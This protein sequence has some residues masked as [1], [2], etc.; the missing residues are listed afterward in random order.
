MMTT[1]IVL[2]ALL[3]GA[4]TSMASASPRTQAPPATQPS[5]PI[6]YS[7]L[8]VGE[9]ELSEDTVQLDIGGGQLVDARV[10]RLPLFIGNVQVIAD[11]DGGRLRSGWEAGM[12]F[13]WENDSISSLQCFGC[14]A[15]GATL[16]FE[17]DNEL[18]LLGTHLGALINIP[19]AQ[20][21]RL[22]ASMG[23]MITFASIEA[24]EDDDVDSIEDVPALLLTDEREYTLDL[25]WYASVGMA[26]VYIKGWEIGALYRRQD[27]NVS[28]SGAY[29]DIDYQG[30]QFMLMLSLPL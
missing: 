3:I 10:R 30:E 6:Q 20:R 17:I 14:G 16:Y 24:D 23:P 18:F 27:F 25:G 26:F 22:F 4:S 7:Q 9:L 13:S 12:S 8:Q 1:I 15:G 2:G 21:G 11:E 29:A 28:F 5:P 19:F